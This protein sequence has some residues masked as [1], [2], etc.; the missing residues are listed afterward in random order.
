MITS[1]K[2]VLK[3]SP[4]EVFETIAEN[5]KDLWKKLTLKQKKTLKANIKCGF[6]KFQ[7]TDK[8]ALQNW[9]KFTN[10]KIQVIVYLA[11]KIAN[12]LKS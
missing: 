1:G 8:N 9:R 7:T 11:K 4:R 6:K 5:L 10:E 3:D 2:K 12:G